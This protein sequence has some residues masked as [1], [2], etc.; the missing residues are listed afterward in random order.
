M[1]SKC[2]VNRSTGKAKTV[3]KHLKVKVQKKCVTLA[4]EIGTASR[5]VP[6]GQVASRWPLEGAGGLWCVDPSTHIGQQGPEY[7]M[8]D[9]GHIKTQRMKIWRVRLEA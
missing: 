7:I 3:N 2:Q 4:V 9:L 1:Q 8:R 6:S 5:G